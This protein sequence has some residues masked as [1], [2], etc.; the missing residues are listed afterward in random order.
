LEFLKVGVFLSGINVVLCWF[1]FLN[2]WGYFV[3]GALDSLICFAGAI[4][5][6]PCCWA[7]SVVVLQYWFLWLERAFWVC[8]VFAGDGWHVIRSVLAVVSFAGY[9]LNKYRHTFFFFAIWFRARMRVRW[10]VLVVSVFVLV[11]LLPFRVGSKTTCSW[12]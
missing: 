4:F 5:S 11:F 1:L 9:Y 3:V 2:P 6:I 8:C 12:I 10:I 7:G